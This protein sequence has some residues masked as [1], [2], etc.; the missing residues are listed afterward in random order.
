[1]NVLRTADEGW[2]NQGSDEE[3]E[4]IDSKARATFSNASVYLIDASL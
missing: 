2:Y 4:K 1:M 3:E